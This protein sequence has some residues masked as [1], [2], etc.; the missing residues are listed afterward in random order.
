MRRGRRTRHPDHAAEQAY[1]ER[2]HRVAERRRAK[3]LRSAEAG[4]DK[5][6]AR[7]LRKREL[8]REPVD[9]DNL[10]FGR[11][12]T[13]A[14]RTH[15]LG[16]DFLYDGAELLVI[17]WRA[18]AA[19]PFY[20][21]SRQDPKGLRRRR[22][23]IVDGPKLV[24]II[25]HVFAAS[26]GGDEP[27]SS[28]TPDGDPSL[29]PH[30]ADAILAEM[31]RAR[32]AEM[33]DIVATIE[34]QQY[35]LISA[36]VDGLLVVQGGPGSGKTA[37]ALHRAAWLLF[38]HRDELARRGVLVVG[39]NR[40]FMEYVASVLPNLGESAV[41]QTTIDRLPDLPE[42]RVRG[43][44]DA[45]VARVKGDIRMAQVVHRAV[46]AR[47]RVPDKTITATVGRRRVA[48]DPS[49]VADLVEEAWRASPT[50]ERARAVF[51]DGLVAR[52]H[53]RLGLSRRDRSGIA[54]D[55]TVVRAS[56]GLLDRI[57][58]TTTAAEVIRDL[59][60]SRRRCEAAAAGLLSKE[61]INLL[62]RPS[63]GSI[64]HE[65]WTAADI[66]LL[67]EADQAIRDSA[68]AYGYVLVDEAQDL[69]PMQLRMVLRRT[70]SGRATL[71]GDIAQATGPVRYADWTELLRAAQ[72]ETEPRIAELRIGYRVPRQ[73]MAL[74]GGLLPRIAPRIAM[75]EAVREGPEEPELV[76]VTAPELV[77]A[78]VERVKRRLDETRSVGVIAP[79]DQLEDVRS[80]LTAAG[81]PAGDVLADGLA[82]KV[83]V[84]SAIQA[85]GLE[86]DHVIV[87]EPA[88]IAAADGG[89]APVYVALTRSTRTLAVLHTTPE[90]FEL[91]PDPDARPEGGG[92]VVAEVAAEDGPSTD[93]TR[94]TGRY[95]EA[96][97]FAK[98][99]HAGQVRRGTTVPYLA[100]LQAVAALVL[101]DGGTEDE[102]IAALLHDAIEDHG[103]EVLDRIVGQFGVEVARIVV[104]CAD[105]EL[106]DEA[107]WRERKAEHLRALE[108]AGPEVRRVALAEKL[109]NARALLR[110]YRRIG[111]RLWS[112]MGVDADQLL[113]YFADLA[114]LFVA[115][116]PGDMASE[117]Q[118]TV[119]ALLDAV[120]APGDAQ[121]EDATSPAA[122]SR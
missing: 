114:D 41:V 69:T 2:V 54:A 19:A 24:D 67:D 3:A 14:G 77:P 110:N 78:L 65:P 117:F 31:E 102:A 70:T 47:V 13:L 98:F 121:P 109:D 93:G 49:E 74:A 15:Y 59:Y 61:E 6:A 39:P 12:D 25:E 84:L 9:P 7:A 57:W 81:I 58:P 86:F 118:R 122:T 111:D 56:R 66:P 32:G 30:V 33:R 83:T 64:R 104:G 8:E 113:E 21:A 36:D 101:E 103:P 79:E 20:N 63:A 45:E 22:Q 92:L 53:T 88:H 40:A 71:V 1:I 120:S 112:Q 85:K 108:S 62:H 34:A 73:V 80:A 52:L 115:E 27:S 4:A 68:R 94:L 119:E 72:V 23:F 50:Y 89:W 96:L 10:C 26:D 97:L 90:P 35:A 29:S 107:S 55:D 16:R 37:V 105:P 11:I 75:P 43:R 95:A 5:A 48:L 76:A 99:L 60:D 44:E 18:P 106:G 17:S 46:R 100:H 28:V 91:P 116:R 42:V 38:N 51:A 87:V 82:R